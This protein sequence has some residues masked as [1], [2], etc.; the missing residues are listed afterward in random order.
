LDLVLIFWSTISHRETN[1][2]CC[3]HPSCFCYV[4]FCFVFPLDQANAL[5]WPIN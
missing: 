2:M 4:H 5:W 1:V 3:I